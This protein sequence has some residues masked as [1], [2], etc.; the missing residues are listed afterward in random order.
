MNE[1]C[2][3]AFWHTTVRSTDL[4]P[5]SSL[6]SHLSL[7]TAQGVDSPHD[8]FPMFVTGIV[9]VFCGNCID[10]RDPSCSVL[11]L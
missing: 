9:Q 5:M 2:K 10:W 4:P 6:V 11:H 7:P 8:G 3:L 1:Y